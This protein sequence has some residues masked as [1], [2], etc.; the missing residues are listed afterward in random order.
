[1]CLSPSSRI[2]ERFPLLCSLPVSWSLGEIQQLSVQQQHLNRSL[3]YG[4]TF[5][6]PSLP[7]SCFGRLPGLIDCI[8]IH[9]C[10]LIS[11][12]EKDGQERCCCCPEVGIKSC[13]VLFHSVQKS[14]LTA[15]RT[16]CAAVKGGFEGSCNLP[17]PGLVLSLAVGLQSKYHLRYCSPT[18]WSCFN[19]FH[20]CVLEEDLS[21]LLP[22]PGQITSRKLG[23]QMRG[24]SFAGR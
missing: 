4:G 13:G 2:G 24:S 6:A 5:S 20:L 23:V 10:Y 1:M 3:Q 17:S 11:S 14:P 9:L 15:Q 22:H 19:Q 16:C 18:D 7:F 21:F 12:L 8:L